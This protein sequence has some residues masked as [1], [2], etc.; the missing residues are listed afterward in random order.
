MCPSVCDFVPCDLIRSHGTKSHTL[1]HMLNASNVMYCTIRTINR[2][3]RLTSLF[4]WAPQF[5]LRETAV[6]CN[7]SH[8]TD[9]MGVC[10]NRTIAIFLVSSPIV[11]NVPTRG[12]LAVETMHAIV[13]WMENL[14]I[15]SIT[16][17]MF[18]N[19][20]HRYCNLQNESSHDLNWVTTTM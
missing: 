19:E 17:S 6:L 3:I 16:T 15:R 10:T 4:P 12:L 2:R 5:K 14:N 11:I 9:C 13:Q 18:V 20:K 8:T 7:L 1:E